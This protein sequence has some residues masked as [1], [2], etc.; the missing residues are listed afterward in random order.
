MCVLC[1]R[2]VCIEIVHKYLHVG[3]SHRF[4]D[5]T[6]TIKYALQHKYYPSTA[7]H[8]T[9][10]LSLSF[11]HKSFLI[12]FGKSFSISST[13]GKLFK[14]LGYFEFELRI[15]FLYNFK[16]PLEMINIFMRCLLLFDQLICSLNLLIVLFN[17][18][19]S[20][21]PSQNFKIR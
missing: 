17:T 15:Q 2:C 7:L 14:I 11:V 20:S 13:V 1:F 8:T 10:H 21:T 5:A 18:T 16:Q 4:P 6:K 3:C 9:R 12:V 19:P